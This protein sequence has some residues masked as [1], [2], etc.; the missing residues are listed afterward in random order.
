MVDISLGV[1]KMKLVGLGALGLFGTFGCGMEP[2]QKESLMAGDSAFDIDPADEF[3]GST[4]GSDDEAGEGGGGAPPPGSSDDTDG[5]DVPPASEGDE[6][7]SEGSDST[8]GTDDRVE[9]GSDSVDPTDLLTFS[10]YVISTKRGASWLTP[11]DI[12]SDGYDE[13]LM[14]SMTEG[15]GASIPPIGPGGAYVLGRT[16]S[17]APTGLGTWELTK[18]F[19]YWDGIIWPN[20][21]TVFDINND[22][23]KDWVIGCGFLAR[24]QGNILWMAGEMN[25]GVLSFGAPQYV[26]IPDSSR[27]YHKVLPLD[28]DGDGDMD[29]VTTNHNKTVF[30]EGTGI[31][32]WYE[33]NG[34]PGEV[35]LTRHEIA[36]GG[37]A[38]LALF[39]V[40]GDG[41]QD[42]ILPQFFEGESLVWME[43][44]GLTTPW[45]RHVI[46]DNTGRGFG[47]EM[48]DMNGDGR[49]DLVYGNH[50]HQLSTVADEKVMGIYW[51][52]IPPAGEVRD[53]A[54]WDAN[55]NV[56]FEG[57]E[58]D[59]PDVDAEGAPGVVHT[60]DVNGDGRMDVSASGD[61]DDGVYVFI[62]QEDG[63]FVENLID[64][65]LTMAGD[66]VMTD[67]DLD[68]D[69][70]FMWAVF[71]TTGLL[72]AESTVYAYLQD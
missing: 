36:E 18:A 6:E 65:G 70:D 49:L 51:W 71:G 53:L 50:N 38:L 15:L 66:H 37:G 69:M 62:Q 35:S 30:E 25:D 72:G 48:A 29:F 26:D 8:D 55:M 23:I 9:D 52:E 46:N 42:V 4:D 22:G 5:T 24:P 7:P 1:H 20:K 68:G 34:V 39:D 21:S 44:T 10:S 63:T 40:D 59:S 28:I 58:I 47:A 41:D 54:D 2:G 14:T 45:V 17:S 31:V 16:A 13:Y 56:V 57:F 64:S 67:L 61:G 11:I 19:D 27:W 32:E 3:V 33:N 60:G 12:D 43:Q